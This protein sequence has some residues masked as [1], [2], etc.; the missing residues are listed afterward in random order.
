MVGPTHLLD[1]LQR[2]SEV[3]I[4]L[5]TAETRRGMGEAMAVAT[6]QTIDTSI[7]LLRLLTV[8]GEIVEI[9][10]QKA[11]QAQHGD[12]SQTQPQLGQSR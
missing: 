1:A 11:L 12:K 4:A 7:G 2:G 3:E 8:E 5:V 9:S 10:I 6:V